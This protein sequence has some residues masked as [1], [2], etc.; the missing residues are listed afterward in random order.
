MITKIV[1]GGQT[2]ADMGGILA[3]IHCEIPYGGWIPKG[4]KCE[5]GRIPE[6][7]H[8]QEMETY[9]YLDRT[10]QNVIDSDATL[11]LTYGL[12]TGG[13]YQTVRLAKRHKKPYVHVDLHWEYEEVVNIIAEWLQSSCPDPCVLNVAG[14]RESKFQG[15]QKAVVSIIVDVIAEANGARISGFVNE[16][17]GK[18]ISPV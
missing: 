7:Y 4:R 13:S 8:F 16:V 1:S 10:E 9:G 5:A 17:N 2:G 15:I 12:P 6:H 11:I 3:A 14:S 18:L